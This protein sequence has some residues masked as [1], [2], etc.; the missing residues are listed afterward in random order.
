[1]LDEIRKPQV[2]ARKIGSVERKARSVGV[3]VVLMG[4]DLTLLVSPFCSHD[5]TVKPDLRSP[6]SGSER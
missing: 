6:A 5:D 4:R 3:E 1:V 2:V